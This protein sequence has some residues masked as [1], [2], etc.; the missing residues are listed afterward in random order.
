[1]PSASVRQYFLQSERWRFQFEDAVRA[2]DHAL[3]EGRNKAPSKDSWQFSHGFHPD[4]CALDRNM[5]SHFSE[6]P[7]SEFNPDD[8]K[9]IMSH[10]VRWTSNILNLEAEASLL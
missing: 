6:I 7:A 9:T 4:T 2:R 5:L 10:P 3:F 1:M 8:W